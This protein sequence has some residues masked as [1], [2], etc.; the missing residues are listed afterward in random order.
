MPAQDVKIVAKKKSGIGKT[1]II[2]MVLASMAVGI[3]SVYSVV[4]LVFGIL[5]GMIALIV[6]Y[7][8]RQYLA[9]IVMSFNAVGVFPYIIQILNSS[10]ANVTA[11]KLITSPKTWLVIYSA[12]GVGWV[13]YSI[14]PQIAMMLMPFYNQ[15]RIDALNKEMNELSEDWGEG[16]RGTK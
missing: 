16:I 3:I 9:K 7:D 6:D 11:M 15:S 1:T 4:I 14:F 2:L 13:I 5:P 8:P 12:A 10:V